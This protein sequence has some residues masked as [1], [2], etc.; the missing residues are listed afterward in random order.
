VT[1][2]GTMITTEDVLRWVRSHPEEAQALLEVD[3]RA[4]AAITRALVARVEYGVQTGE[5]TLEAIGRMARDLGYL[6]EAVGELP[7]PGK[8]KMGSG[9]LGM[10]SV[11]WSERG[12]AGAVGGAVG[13]GG[14]VAIVEVAKAIVEVLR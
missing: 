6:R 11:L 10:V 13:A 3:P 4:L 9:L 2:N 1:A 8:R 7:D 14:I 12:R 5:E